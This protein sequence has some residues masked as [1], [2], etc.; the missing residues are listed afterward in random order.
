V[1]HLFNA[2]ADQKLV[3]VNSDEQ[4]VQ[5]DRMLYTTPE[6]AYKDIDL[7]RYIDVI[8]EILLND[9]RPLDPSIFQHKLNK[10]FNKSYSK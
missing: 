10:H 2:I 5:V 4:I 9:N 7:P 6:I 8:N 3:Q 1:V